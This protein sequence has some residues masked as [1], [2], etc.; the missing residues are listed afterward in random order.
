MSEYKKDSLNKG[1]FILTVSSFLSKFLGFFYVIPFIALVGT[2][3]NILFEYAYKPYVILLS[4]A[5]MGIPLAVSKLVSKYNGLGD[6]ETGRRLIKS[7]LVVTTL[8]GLFWFFVLFLS[9]PA[10][11]SFLIA[12]G[13]TTGNS[14]EH[15][16]FVIKMVSF[17]IIIVPPMAIIR[18]FF[19]GY[20]EMK[21]TAYSQLIEQ[22]VRIL[23]ILL[24]VFIVIKF[25]EKDVYIAVGFATLAATIGAIAGFLS[26]G[27]SW[28]KRKKYYNSL[29]KDSKKSS[30]VSLVSIYKE[31]IKYAI[32]FVIVG[33][34]IT[35]YQSIDT[36][37][38][39]KAMVSSGHTQFEAEEVNSIIALCQKLIFIPMALAA[40]FGTALVPAIT[41]AFTSN[42]SELVKHHVFK[43]IQIVVFFTLPCVI[44]LAI[45]SEEAFG[46]M[47]GSENAVLGGELLA[48]S[49]STTIV[50]SLS[51]V[52]NAILQGLDKQREAL[53]SLFLGLFLK[54][55]LTFQFVVWYDGIGTVLTTNIGM[56]ISIVYSLFVI[57]KTLNI[58][59]ATNTAFG[60]KMLFILASNLTLAIVI[61]ISYLLNNI[62]LEKIDNMIIIYILSLLI[63]GSI[64][65]ITYLLISIKNGI[66]FEVIGN[67]FSFLQKLKKSSS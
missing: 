21:P 33:L 40:G 6:Y 19:Q 8:T 61:Y 3:G 49:A 46:I 43:T 39:N 57:F 29:L 51:L 20:E 36:F 31:L 41:K 9:A 24:S 27:I 42:N 37:L 63:N 54:L 32:P 59:N 23:F 13:D 17:A 34:G 52:T 15:V 11:A 65:G 35:L 30:D 55:I 64:G 7:G 58:K 25:L 14:L 38:I 60:E 16:T 1:A 62:W 48:W 4:M 66:L 22:I 67:R 53:I 2:Q 50:F 5:T 12:E 47:F 45:L 18:G 56:I 10:I 26:L 28:F 44:L